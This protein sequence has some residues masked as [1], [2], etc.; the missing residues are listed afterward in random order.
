M[1]IILIHVL[2]LVILTTWQ[3]ENIEKTGQASFSSALLLTILIFSRQYSPTWNKDLLY[4]FHVLRYIFSYFI[5]LECDRWR[6]THCP[7]TSLRFDEDDE[8]IFFFFFRL[9]IHSY[10][11][12]SNSQLFWGKHFFDDKN[13]IVTSKMFII[14]S[15][16]LQKES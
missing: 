14:T 13:V 7:R 12:C 11:L 5:F 1:Y 4:K 8:R 16:L 15:F 9:Y 10:Q 3:S 2:F 6:I